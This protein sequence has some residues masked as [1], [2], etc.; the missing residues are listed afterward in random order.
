MVLRP[1]ALIGP[2][3][4]LEHLGAGH[5]GAVYE[6]EHL[7]TSV[8]CAMR[9]LVERFASSEA[10][11]ERLRHDAARLS[12][13][14]T[15]PNVL[16]QTEVVEAGDTLAVV[17]ELAEGGDLERALERRP[18]PLAWSQAR[19][20]L[21]PVVAAVAAGH[22]LGLVHR[23][24][25]PASVLLRPEG[26]WPGLPLVAD[27]G[28]AAALG[29]DSPAGP[30]TVGYRAPE[31]LRG[32]SEVGPAADVWALGMLAWRLVNGRLPVAPEDSLSLFRLYEGATPVPRL[33][34]VPDSLADAVAAALR[35]EARQRPQDASAFLRIWMPDSRVAPRVARGEPQPIAA[36]RA[37][38]AEPGHR[39]TFVPPPEEP[40]HR[41]MFV[42]PPE[43]ALLRGMA[44]P[45][46]A[47]VGPQRA[48]P[49]P[50]AGS[51]PTSV[52]TGQL[53]AGLAGA[54]LVAGAVGYGLASPRDGEPPSGVSDARP[55]PAAT[56]R[57]D[58]GDE[59][60]EDEAGDGDEGR[61]RGRGRGASTRARADEE[62]GE[63]GAEGRRTESEARARRVFPDAFTRV[64]PGTF[65]M[66]TPPSEHERGSNERQREVTI[67]RS[68]WIGKFEVTQAEW[69]A[70]FGSNPSPF[71][72]CGPDCPV[73]NV[74][75]E[76]AIH[77]VNARSRS[78]GLELCYEGGVFRGLACTGYRLPTEAE[79]EYAARAGWK[80][81]RHGPVDAV[82]WFRD[83][84]NSRTHP[85]GQKLPNAWGL[86]DTLGNVWEWTHD[87]N[88]PYSGEGVSDPTGPSTGEARVIRGGSWG[89]EA[90][91]L[92]AGNRNSSEPGARGLHIGLRVARTVPADWAP[93]AVPAPTTE[94]S[95]G[96]VRVEPGA[97][98]MGSP[99][100]EAGRDLEEVPHEVTLTRA[101]WIGIHEVTWD[102][103]RAT[104][105]DVAS[106]SAACGDCPVESVSWEDAA[107]FANAWSR[108]EGLEECYQG[109]RFL[110]LRCTGYRLPTEAEWEYA[111]RAGSEEARY[112]PVHTIAWY[113]RNS[114]EEPMSV[115][116][117][118]ANAWGL[119][120]MLGNVSE[121]V[122]DWHEA[123][124]GDAT[125]PVGPASGAQRAYRGGDWRSAADELRAARR[126][127]GPP[128]AR[129]D[130]VG[131]R[132]ARTAVDAR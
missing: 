124:E 120:D 2:Y 106:R 70:V 12:R 98:R 47:N 125:D 123:Y 72:A 103:W 13:L 105:G 7:T 66:G 18:G 88:G 73:D 16:R 114:D 91:A 84:S 92:R 53:W 59:R 97:F 74:S 116:W 31:Q 61:G 85:V 77:Y 17:H 102:E 119:H 6:V 112:G 131:F 122:H 51:R 40:G 34:G 80:E 69:Q 19:R 110:G 23:E 37:P 94:P 126:F 107:R 52:T 128:D 101:F 35:P 43:E 79:W 89:A 1:K 38:E 78:E 111:A 104:L 68:F 54:A 27:F 20:L 36:P 55:M 100:S 50:P 62:A 65:T 99:D 64:M 76:D 24:L 45:A 60:G 87:W 109:E 121:W 44:A 127:Q 115:G 118:R 82:G 42:P 83:N 30:K 113:E 71:A 49:R 15:H 39:T 75:W 132:L 57:A 130:H 9:V 10:V 58:P 11:R 117:K 4:V 25:R 28:L 32:A 26:P 108:R 29:E 129:M 81:M 93:T 3:R 67:S 5:A 21:E 14:G 96:F 90:K 95:E 33:T 56:N 63:D 22:A 48:G 8:R 46:A 41:T 86:Y